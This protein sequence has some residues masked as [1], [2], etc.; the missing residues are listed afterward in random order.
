ML[1][2]I[3]RNLRVPAVIAK[4]VMST[5]VPTANAPA[6]AANAAGTQDVLL[7]VLVLTVVLISSDLSCTFHVDLFIR[8]GTE[9]QETTI[10]NYVRATAL[11]NE[12]LQ[13]K[14]LGR[15]PDIKQ[16]S[17]ANLLATKREVLSVAFFQEFA[18]FLKNK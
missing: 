4:A 17:S 15:L 18:T 10:K 3:L 11:L 8:T 5:P 14:G 6:P 2:P 9:K 12:F 1:F 16:Q 13:K 7:R